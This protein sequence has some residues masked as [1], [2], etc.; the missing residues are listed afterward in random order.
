MYSESMDWKLATIVVMKGCPA[1]LARTLRSLRTCST[2]L[3]R[4]TGVVSGCTRDVCEG[5]R[6]VDLAQY[7]QGKDAVCVALLC[8]FQAHQPDARKGAG[9]EGLDELKVLLA[10]QLARVA[11]GLVVRV[12]VDLV[13]G[14]GARVGLPLGEG[15]LLGLARLVH[16]RVVAVVQ[17]DRGLARALFLFAVVLDRVEQPVDGGR[18][19][20][21]AG[22]GV[23]RS[24]GCFRAYEG[25]AGL[26]VGRAEQSRGRGLGAGAG[27]G[28]GADGRPEE[29]QPSP[30]TRGRL[31]VTVCRHGG[32]FLSHDAAWGVARAATKPAH[33]PHGRRPTVTANAARVHCTPHVQESTY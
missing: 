14:E 24:E 20:G 11:D 8:I 31:D 15:A 22:A 27:A 21:R 25:I 1:T 12:L 13:W 33:K 7:L 23:A 2:C 6:T 17:R 32:G 10:Q 4:M 18:H 26:G 3:R 5:V 9:A 19:G 16:G 29:W 30:T 28:A